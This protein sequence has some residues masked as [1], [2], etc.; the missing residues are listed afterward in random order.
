M[1]KFFKWLFGIKNKEVPVDNS[2]FEKKYVTITHPSIKRKIRAKEIPKHY[3]NQFKQIKPNSFMYN[4][5][6]LGSIGYKPVFGDVDYDNFTTTTYGGGNFGGGGA[7]GEWSPSAH[8]AAQAVDHSSSNDSS[9][10]DSSS[11]DSG[12]SCSSCGGGD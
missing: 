4:V 10:N 9:S 5:E 7:S 6:T 3:T 8:N 2:T 12:S 11:S 1:T